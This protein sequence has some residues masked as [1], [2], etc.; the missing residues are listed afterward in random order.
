MHH[1]LGRTATDKITGFKG[2]VT[3]R[4]EYLTGCNQL[5]IAPKV[6]SDGALKDSQWFDEQRCEFDDSAETVV[7]NNGRTPG[8]DRAAPK[9]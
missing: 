9:R 4:V 5:L 8:P 6:G 1:T 3:G 7:L 2:V